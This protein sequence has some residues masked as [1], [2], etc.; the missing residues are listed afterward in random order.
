MNYSP[1]GSS[2]RI[3]FSKQWLPDFAIDDST[4][5][6]C[7]DPG[8][9]EFVTRFRRHDRETPSESYARS[10]VVAVVDG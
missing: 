9:Y 8:T 3:S 10:F 6:G 7:Y 5:D 2:A 4:T 1:S